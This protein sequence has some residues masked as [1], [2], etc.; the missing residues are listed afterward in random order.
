M[1][2]SDEALT[3]VPH[4]SEILIGKGKGKYIGKKK[5]NKKGWEQRQINEPSNVVYYIYTSL[6]LVLIFPNF[7]S[8]P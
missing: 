8:P 7:F 2:K 5:R 1:R 4:M 3:G 6:S